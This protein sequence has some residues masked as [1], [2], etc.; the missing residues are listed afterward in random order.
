M[1]KAP[2]RG[3]RGQAEADPAAI[4]IKEKKGPGGADILRAG[5]AAAF[6]PSGIDIPVCTGSRQMRLRQEKH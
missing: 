1:P 4:S 5:A 6:A 2:G 3:D